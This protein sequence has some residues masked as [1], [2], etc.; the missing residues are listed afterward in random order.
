MD[1]RTKLIFAFVATSLISMLAFGAYGYLAAADVLQTL[2]ARQLDALASARVQDIGVIVEAWRDEVRLIQSRTE[3]RRRLAV[4]D[5][6]SAEDR[7]K[8][9][10]I[11]SDAEASVDIITQVSVYDRDRQLVASAGSGASDGEIIGTRQFGDFGVSQYLKRADGGIDALLS[12]ELR[13]N[14]ERVGDITTV[15]DTR[16]LMRIVE[17]R[18][19]L[20][21]SGE[22]M[23]VAEFSPGVV[24]QFNPPRHGRGDWLGSYAL[25]RASEMVQQALRSADVRLLNVL[26]YRGKPVW[27]AV[28]SLEGFPGRLVVKIDA[29]EELAQVRALRDRMI[30]VAL[31][32]AALAI[33]AGALVGIW[34]ARPVRRLNQIVERIRGGEHELRADES[35][36]DEVSFL[37]ESFN[38]LMDQISRS[39]G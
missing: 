8:I 36:E 11:I 5:P 10:Q 27:A 16:D 21:D 32:V 15:V 14:G 19:G 35:G 33:L 30:D 9:Q 7:E 25:E 4:Y 13:Q 3:L 34:L 37:A 1:I 38:D 29:A 22:M 12:A 28:R 39:R 26:D 31:S 17:S 23:L 18:S 2:S 6:D 20:G 24:T